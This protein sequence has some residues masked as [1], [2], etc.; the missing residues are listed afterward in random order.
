MKP[1]RR[2][3]G[4]PPF[5]PGI[6]LK[7]ADGGRKL[8]P[9]RKGQI[10]FS[11]GD[12]ATAVFYIHR[13]RVKLTTVSKQGKDAVIGILGPEEFFGE[14]SL[15]SQPVR[16]ATAAAMTAG[17]L[18]RIEKRE[19]LRVLAAEP[20][21]SAFFL[22]CVLSR[23]TRIEADLVDQL[24]NS[25]EKRLARALLLLAKFG[26]E[27]KP[28]KTVPKIDQQTLADMIG[29]TRSRVSYFMNKFRKLG[30]IDYD[31]GIH[32]NNSLLKVLLRG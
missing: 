9:F 22:G 1:P 7:T 30:Y 3:P 10:F 14:G 20:K 8:V 6:Y 24:F 27:G 15:G 13:G 26:Q 11:Q 2:K 23:E 25:S 5:D 17:S 16:L 18:L 32:V 29:T 12:S 31:G 4:D 19:M 28:E 21:L